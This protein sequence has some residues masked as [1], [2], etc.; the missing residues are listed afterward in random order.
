GKKRER[1]TV[2]L[3][4]RHLVFRTEANQLTQLGFE[5]VVLFAQRNDL[6]FGNR[7]RVSAMRVRDEDF[8]DHV[9]VIFEELRV[10]L[11]IFCNGV[12]IHS[13]FSSFGFSAIDIAPSA[14]GGGVSHTPSNTLVA[15]PFID[16]GRS[17]PS[18][19]IVSV[20]PRVATCTFDSSKPRRTPATTAAH[21]PVPHASVS[22]AP[23][24]HTRNRMLARPTTC[25]YPAFTRCGKRGCCSINGPCV[26][27]GAASTSATNWTA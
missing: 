4:A 6:P 17:S 21:A 8:G 9:G 2:D 23:R 25:M 1:R 20:P 5:L 13:L 15:A 24:S 12:Y 26:V 16:T 10:V 18:Q 7:D 3:F 27:T 11:Q 19:L 14:Y 22:P